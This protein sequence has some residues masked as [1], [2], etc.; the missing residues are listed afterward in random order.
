MQF[1]ASETTIPNYA[2]SQL[3]SLFMHFMLEIAKCTCDGFATGESF[4]LP[5]LVAPMFAGRV[6]IHVPVVF[7]CRDVPI[8]ATKQ[9]VLYAR[10]RQ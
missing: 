1:N 9:T 10:S 8:N 2:R 4:N 3:C 5:F 6:F 7:D